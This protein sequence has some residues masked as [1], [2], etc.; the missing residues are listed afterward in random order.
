MAETQLISSSLG[1]VVGLILALTGAG[2]GILAV[3]LLI[4][5]LH[6]TVA[7]AGPISLLAVAIAAG[8]GAALGL[9]AGVVRYRA[10]GMIASTGLVM[11]P[12]GIWLAQ[13]I[14]NTPLT[15]LFIVVL[16]YVSVRMLKQAAAELR[17]DTATAVRA[18][19]PCQ[20]DPA[21]GRLRWSLPCAR[22]LMFSGTLAGLASGLLGVGGGFVI[23]PALKTVSDLGMRSIVATSL[24]VLMLVSAGG[25]AAA[26]LSGHMAWTLALP[27]AGGAIAGMYV[28]G[29]FSNRVAGPRLQQTF[30]V[31]AMVV[32][33]GLLLR[34]T[35]HHF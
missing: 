6:L 16:I 29:L 17:G 21:V 9:K 14:P 32:A 34:T 26:A 25:V 2:G 1:L 11:S 22:A 18:A 5:G 4:F 3:P 24:A 31:V 30:A 23:V 13:R 12:I 10:A 27:F 8:V 20:V 35:L 19:P 28:G 7:Q 33:I 15:L